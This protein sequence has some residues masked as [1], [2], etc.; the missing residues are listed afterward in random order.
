MRVAHIIT[1]L[2]L[3]GPVRLPPTVHCQIGSDE[4]AARSVMSVEHTIG[5]PYG[6]SCPRYSKPV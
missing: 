6:A 4:D 3:Q 1:F 2:A 5:L